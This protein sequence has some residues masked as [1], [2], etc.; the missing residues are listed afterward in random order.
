[1]QTYIHLVTL[2][3]EGRTTFLD[4]PNPPPAETAS[5]L[6][7]EIL[8]DYLTLGRFDIV[9][10][11]SFPDDDAAARFALEM[12]KTGQSRSETMRA[13]D[14]ESFG[15]LVEGMADRSGDDGA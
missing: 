4:G 9:V 8:A 13:F 3:D 14:T 15:E 6:G 5:R 12:N 11:S 2:T 1:M 10:V 7:G